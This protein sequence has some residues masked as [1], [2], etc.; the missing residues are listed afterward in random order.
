RLSGLVTTPL[1]TA[2]R[3]VAAVTT[4]GQA[5]VFEVSAANDKAG[6]TILASREAQKEEPLAQFALLHDGHLWVAGNQLTKLAILPTGNQLPVRGLERNFRGDSFD[7]P[8]QTAGKLLI[9]L[10]RPAGSAGAIVAATDAEAAPIWETH[11]AV[12]PAGPPAVDSSG[13]RIT[14]GAASGVVYLLDREAMTRRVQNEAERLAVVP[15]ALPVFTDSI[16]LAQGRLVLGGVGGKQLLHFRPGNP[17][18]S[19]KAVDL[20]G[21]LSCPPVAW[22]DGFVAATNVG[23]VALLN[24][25]DASPV[26]TPFQPEL[27]PGQEYRW[28]RPAVTGAAA[29][30]PLVISD[31]IR[32]L[33]LINVNAQPQPHLEAITTVPVDGAPLVT[34]LAVAGERVFAGTDKNQLASYTLPDLKADEP[35]ALESR[36]AWGPHTAGD[37]VLLGLESG[38]LVAV[39]A[40]GAVRWRQSLKHGE[41][42][43]APLVDGENA[44]L[45]FP[46]GGIARIALANGAEAAYTELGQPA[47]AGPVA[48]GPRLVVAAPDGTLL[49]V[50][51]P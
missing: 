33:Y 15:A 13:L 25:D 34:P 14:A 28:L 48:F 12:P 23:Q 40:D 49:I 32:K 1:Q 29:D 19:L 24:A 44:F 3:R 4:L 26:V 8:L 38:E 2:A 9:H 39:G 6:L 31:G 7:F 43:G 11:L 36:V 42:G 45:L 37:A 10:R 22:R 47:I 27:T 18:E 50:N 16:D 20:A 35:I 30:S 51:R 21:P 41:L 5:A 17:R 46:T